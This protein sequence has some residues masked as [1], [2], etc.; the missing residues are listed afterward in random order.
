MYPLKMLFGAVR[1]SEVF[2][3]FRTLHDLGRRPEWQYRLRQRDVWAESSI[4]QH[5]LA[6]RDVWAESPLSNPLVDSGCRSIPWFDSVQ[7]DRLVVGRPH[8]GR[9]HYVTA[10]RVTLA[11]NDDRISG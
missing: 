2:D 8:V 4:G 11:R 6:Q 3:A 9:S 10:I 7:P 1:Y 5:R